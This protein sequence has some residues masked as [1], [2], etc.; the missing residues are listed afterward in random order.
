MLKRLFLSLCVVALLTLVSAFV[1]TDAFAQTAHTSS[2]HP[3]L[4]T[5]HGAGTG[6]VT[7]HFHEFAFQANTGS[8]WTTGSDNHGSWNLGMAAGTSPSLTALADGGY[9][10]AVQDN[11][12]RLWTVGADGSQDWGLGMAAGTSPSITALADGGYE[13]AFQANTGTL[14]TGGGADS[15]HDTGLPMKAGTSPSITWLRDTGSSINNYLVAFQT[16]FGLLSVETNETGVGPATFLPPQETF[17]LKAGTSPSL[18]TLADGNN[19]VAFQ[20]NLGSLWTLGSQPE[21]KPWNLG[22]QAGTSPA[23]TALSDGGY[24]VAFQANNGTL[25]TVG[26]DNHGSWSVGMQAGTSPSLTALPDQGSLINRY[27]VAFQATNGDLS[28]AGSGGIQDMSL[29]MQAGTSPGIEVQTIN[30]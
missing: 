21:R 24:E 29:G 5:P 17:F 13:V 1:S 6:A 3:S 9:E 10:V 19:E 7:L 16:N 4:A 25:W 12:G 14:W 23:I 22:V 27:R 26:P 20:D 28:T 18:T 11:T 8:L 2:P 15:F 30:G